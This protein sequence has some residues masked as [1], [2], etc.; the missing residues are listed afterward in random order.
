VPEKPAPVFTLCGQQ[1]ATAGNI[2]SLY[3]QAKA[4]KS[5]VLSAM[6]AAAFSDDAPLRLPW[7]TAAPNTPGRALVHFDTEQSRYDA[8]QLIRRA[9]R[10][11]EFTGPP[12]TWLRS[13]WL[14]DIELACAARCSATS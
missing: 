10:R 3:S 2:I 7:L 11:A 13:Y 9:L 1:I 4:G 6:M 14:T 12:P 5:A 8:D